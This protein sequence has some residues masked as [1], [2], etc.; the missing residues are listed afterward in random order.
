MER[1]DRT[2]PWWS[3]SKGG[4]GRFSQEKWCNA[5]PVLGPGSEPSCHRQES[6]K[7]RMKNK[8]KSAQWL[9]TIASLNSACYLNVPILNLFLHTWVLTGC[10]T[11]WP[12][13]YLQLHE[14]LRQEDY[15]SQ[16]FKAR[17]NN[18]VRAS[19]GWS[20]KRLFGPDRRPKELINSSIW[21]HTK[22]QFMKQ[23]AKLCSCPSDF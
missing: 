20:C 17:I 8:L 10:W 3:A 13:L 12:C 4:R 7:A 2:W 15:W 1:C 5:K 23:M 21:R 6:I 22:T 14:G 19:G 18:I 16:Q 11:W 9:K